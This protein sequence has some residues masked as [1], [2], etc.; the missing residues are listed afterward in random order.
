MVEKE[1]E[2]S[3]DL[4]IEQRFHRQII[5][6]KG[7]RIKVIRESFNQVVIIFPEP[8]DKSDKVTIRGTR[9][10]VDQCYKH[11]SQLNKEL[12]TNNHRVE[13]PI[14]KQFHK[15]IIGKEG[16]NIKKIRDETGTRIDLPAEGADSD[17]I[18]ITGMKSNV[19]T[20][21]DRI[22]TIQNELEDVVQV[23]IMIPSK[24]HNYIIGA[25]GRQIRQIMDDC[26]GVV[27]RF[28]PEGA[29]SDKVSIRGPKDCVQKAKQQL[30]AI[31]NEQQIN[32]FSEEL[33]I[34]PEHHR[35][36][37]GKNGANIKKVRDNAGA[38]V[39]FPTGKEESAA[40]RDSV[41]ITGKKEE[42]I[43]A[44]QMLE[45][46]VKDLEKVVEG[47]M[48]VEPK[49]HKHFVARRGAILKQIGDEFG[50]VTISFPRSAQRD[51]DRVVLKGAK[52]CIESAKQR[53]TEIIEDLDSQITIECVIPSKY[54]RTLMGTRGTRVQA[55]TQEHDVRI[56]FPERG[57]NGV[58]GDEDVANGDINGS[59]DSLEKS[60]KK[61]DIII[62]TGRAEKCESAQNALLALIPIT[63]EV[64]VPFDLHRF[65]IGQKG[66]E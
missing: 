61:S 59:T 29:G 53:I 21:R 56:K 15:F 1:N 38:R 41:I 40:D 58:A 24:I 4:M 46:M 63:I 32:N 65:I 11:L 30:I 17:V 14:F 23:D 54:H 20:A 3:K 19:E 2:V 16:A 5:G 42:V 62:I 13:V 8:N 31:S 44:R 22:Q 12:L 50:G 6:A 47:E 25:K 37:I 36:L 45:E 64:E 26:G 34:K 57:T 18:V 7:E 51:S 28:P 9:K 49:Y 55:I 33:K 52:E 39:F 27:I 35:Y 43:K 66:R 60:Q 10:D 48:K